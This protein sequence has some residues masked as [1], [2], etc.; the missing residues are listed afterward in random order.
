MAF[1][2]I[3]RVINHETIGSRFKL[4]HLAGL[5]ARELNEPTDETFMTEY[6]TGQK[7]T[8]GALSDIVFSKIVFEDADRGSSTQVNTT[9]T[10]TETS[11][12][13]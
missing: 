2:D 11:T 7:V 8:S 3:E 1:L 9:L 6:K 10:D 5:R 13:E 12:A 4:V